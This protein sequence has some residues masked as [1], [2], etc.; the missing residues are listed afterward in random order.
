MVHLLRDIN[1]ST[2]LT[3]K[4][5]VANREL[6]LA[7]RFRV[8]AIGFCLVDSVQ[9]IE[10]DPNLSGINLIRKPGSDSEVFIR[11]SEKC[12]VLSDVKPESLGHFPWM[13]TWETL[14]V[15]SMDPINL[16]FTGGP[17]KGQY[18]S[19]NVDSKSG[20]DLVAS[21]YPCPCYIAFVG[22]PTISLAATLSNDFQGF[23]GA[24]YDTVATNDAMKDLAVQIAK[25]HKEVGAFFIKDHLIS[26]PS[27]LNDVV[28][29]IPD[30]FPGDGN[31]ND[32]TSKTNFELWPTH[33]G[34][35]NRSKHWWSEKLY[36]ERFKAKCETT[37]EECKAL[38]ELLVH[39][40]ALGQCLRQKSTP[41]W[42]HSFKQKRL[43]GMRCL[44][45][46]PGPAPNN[47]KPIVTTAHHRDATYVTLLI[48]S[49]PGLQ[50]KTRANN[51]IDVPV[52]RNNNAI[53]VNTGRALEMRSDGFYPA[54]CHRVIR[55]D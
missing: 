30:V 9:E 17:C 37:F 23:F 18:L 21:T 13:S 45:Y 10:Q 33:L 54:V 53:L 55:Q 47:G 2:E 11:A 39:L 50:I 46:Q 22:I 25:A 43:L 19:C 14:K 31:D 52:R 34:S 35:L 4:F 29:L 15:T 48:A 40:L 28:D 36:N 32:S 8:G 49:H 7:F 24:S 1:P 20:R 26:L 51:W 44:V 41:A 3:L 16:Q 5:K 27:L 12:K 42:A 6:H 38:S